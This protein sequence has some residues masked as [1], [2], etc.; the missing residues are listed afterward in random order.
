MFQTLT[1]L[2]WSIFIVSWLIHAYVG[3][4]PGH[5]KPKNKYP[6]LRFV[7]IIAML[8]LILDSELLRPI[9][10]SHFFPDNPA[11]QGIGA[12]LCVAGIMWAVHARNYLGKNG[13]YLWTPKQ[14]TSLLQQG[15]IV[16]F[17]ILFIRVLRWQYWVRCLA[18]AIYG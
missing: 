10:D 8:S 17:V 11:M 4:K 2:F 7:F 1:I 18:V 9:G 13:D 16:W 12:L 6:I 15:R 5:A 3:K 14:T